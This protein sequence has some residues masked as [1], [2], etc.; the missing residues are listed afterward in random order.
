MVLT[1]AMNAV[2][3][4]GDETRQREIRELLDRSQER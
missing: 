1:E 4:I 2:Q 3:R